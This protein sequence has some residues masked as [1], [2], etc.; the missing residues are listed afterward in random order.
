MTEQLHAIDLPRPAPAPD[1]GPLD[2]HLYDLVEARVRRVMADNPIVATFFGI[3]AEDHR[4]GDA[5]RDA[6]E[7]EIAADRAHLAAVEALDPAGLS[8]AARFERDLELHNL[9]LGLFETGEIRR[10]E[11]RSS[12]AGDLGDAVLRVG[13]GEIDAIVRVVPHGQQVLGHR[14]KPPNQRVV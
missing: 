13:G 14:S 8:P 4:L 10:W 3:H 5:S 1:A 7:G 2:D 9:R 11:R 12:A 6:M